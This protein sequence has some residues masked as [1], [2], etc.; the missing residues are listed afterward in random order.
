ML[1]YILNRSWLAFFA[2]TSVYLIVGRN[3]NFSSGLMDRANR[4]AACR[5]HV[6][7]AS[8]AQTGVL[9]RDFTLTFLSVASPIQW[10]RNKHSLSCFLLLRPC[11]WKGTA[12][13]KGIYWD[14]QLD[15]CYGLKPTVRHL[16]ARLQ[17]RTPDDL[18]S[19]YCNLLVLLSAD[20]RGS[21]VSLCCLPAVITPHQRLC[22][23]VIQQRNGWKCGCKCSNRR[24]NGSTR[25]KMTRSPD[26]Y[27]H[28][29]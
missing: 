25:R 26:L 3:A 9:L 15:R 19:V 29:C 28:D 18:R 10:S 11:G 16:V 13:P 14:T 7:G 20:V 1:R 21:C 8:Q 2:V 17:H 12:F 24:N 5:F 27:E 4:P 6:V 22:C 23:R